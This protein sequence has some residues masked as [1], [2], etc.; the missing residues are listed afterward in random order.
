MVYA[1]CDRLRG[2]G[3]VPQPT[4]SP[5]VMSALRRGD[6]AALGRAL[7]NDLQQAAISLQPDLQGVLDAGLD[8]GA[9]GGIV[10]GSGPTVAFLTGSA[11]HALDLCVALTAS[12]VAREVRRAK[13][14][15]HGA[16]LIPTVVAD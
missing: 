12:G 2:R 14:P 15:V 1:E 13:G 4:P 10:C 5:Q 8:F 3:P 16:Q 6:P 11:E 9:L 7:N